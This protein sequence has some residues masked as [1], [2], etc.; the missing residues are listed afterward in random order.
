M[1]IIWDENPEN[2]VNK[3]IAEIYTAAIFQHN[4]NDVEY[5]KNRAEFVARCRELF[6]LGFNDGQSYVWNVR[7]GNFV[8][9]KGEP[10]DINGNPRVERPQ[11]M[12]V[13]T[14]SNGSTTHVKVTIS[15]DGTKTECNISEEEA[16]EWEKT[17]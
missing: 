12:I 6:E 8:N 15:P 17:Q 11:E 13:T 1:S 4:C 14:N 16:K 7:R 5:E 9:A 10:V 2:V 3:K